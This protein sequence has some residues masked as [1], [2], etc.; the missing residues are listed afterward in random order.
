MSGERIINY[1]LRL[2]LTRTFGVTTAGFLPYQTVTVK[3]G[4]QS[5]QFFDP[6]K[7]KLA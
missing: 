2:I 1:P 4:I 5:G 7:G 3:V 6:L